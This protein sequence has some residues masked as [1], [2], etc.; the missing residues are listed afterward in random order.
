MARV[1]VVHGRS[2]IEVLRVPRR[3]RGSP[4]THSA[5]TIFT[6]SSSKRLVTLARIFPA[7]LDTVERLLTEG[8]AGVRYLV[9]FG[10]IEDIQ[11]VAS[12][13]CDWSFADRIRTSAI[14]RYPT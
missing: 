7:V 4:V 1:A 14:G 2:G 6:S 10:L 3:R 13:R 5:G 11:D 9:T 8:D 12:N